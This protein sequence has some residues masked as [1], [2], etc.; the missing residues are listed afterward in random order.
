MKNRLLIL[1]LCLLP[2]LL[3]EGGQAM[4]SEGRLRERLRERMADKMSE[5]A[6][7]NGEH[8]FSGVINAEANTCAEQNQKV[9]AIKKRGRMARLAEGPVPDLANVKYGSHPLQALDVF[10]ARG[11]GVAAAPVIV[12]VHGGGWCV[13]DKSMK[14]VTA[15]KVA[16]WTAKGFVF[17]SVNYPMVMDGLDALA[18]ADEIAQATAYIQQHTHEWGGDGRRVILM[19]HS[20]GAHLVSLVNADSSIRQRAGVKPLLGTVSLD[21]GAVDVPRQMPDVIPALTIRYREAFGT[22]EAIWVKASPHHQLDQS[23][24]PWLGVCSTTRPDDPCGQAHSYAEKSRSL[25]VM[26]DV[27]ALPKG[28]G[29]LNSELGQPG[30]YTDKVEKFMASLDPLVAARLGL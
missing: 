20:A 8:E 4:A 30:A 21:S 17:V 14:G 18:Q 25:G 19:G 22:E 6:D 5:Q 29:A 12:M 16:R 11:G 26:A 7:D 15:N 27:L 13:G 23:A 1:T 28:H 10:K 3:A 24:A 2:V 9:E